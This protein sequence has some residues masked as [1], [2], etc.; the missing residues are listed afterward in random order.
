MAVSDVSEVGK[1]VRL[2]KSEH[3]VQIS[4]ADAPGHEV[5]TVQ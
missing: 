5:H 1:D 2:A 3:P 4:Q